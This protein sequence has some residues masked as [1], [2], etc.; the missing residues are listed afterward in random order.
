MKKANRNQV[1]ISYAHEDLEMAKKVVE[2]LKKRELDLWFD[3]ERLKT[4]RWKPKIMKAIAQSRYF[5]ICISDSA[6]GKIEE[7]PGFID[8]ELNAAY[9]IAMNQ[10]DEE[11]AIVPIRLEDCE[12][13]KLIIDFET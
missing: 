6:L 5:L 7:A 12:R 1:F 11:F 13:S 10:A 9:Q 4:G 3:K 8:E 2:G